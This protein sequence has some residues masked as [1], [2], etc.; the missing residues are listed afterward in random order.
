MATVSQ[1]RT[2]GEKILDETIVSKVL[3]SLTLKFDHDVA[4]IEE[5]KDLSILSID[6]LMGS[7]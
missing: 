6:E 3:R 5:A 1:M 7:L 4:V 2:Y